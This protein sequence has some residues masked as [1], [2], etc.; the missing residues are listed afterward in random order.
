MT[1]LQALDSSVI[2]TL[3]DQIAARMAAGNQPADSITF[4]E[5]YHHYFERH[6]KVRLKNWQNAHYFFK[7]HGA[8]WSSIK[9]HEI[10]RLDVQAWVDELGKKSPSS[11]TRALNMVKAIINWGMRRELIPQMLNPC[12]GVE[13]FDTPS[14]ERFVLPAELRKLKAALDDECSLMCD[15]FWISL[16]TGARRSN[17]LSMRW[18]EIDFDLATWTIPASKFKNGGS[19]TVPL[20]A[21]VL[22]VL[23]RRLED[24][25]TES[26]WVF[27]GRI[28][29]SHLKEPKRAWQRILDRAEISDLHIHDLRRTMG[30]YMAMNGENQYVIAQMLGHKDLRSTAVYARLNLVT[31]RSASE[32]VS[33]K[34]QKYLDA[35]PVRKVKPLAQKPE[36]Q[37]IQFKNAAAQLSP[38]E[39]L[40]VEGRILTSLLSGGSTKKHFYSR[41][42]SK[43]QVNSRELD[44]VLVEMESRRLIQKRMDDRGVTRYKLA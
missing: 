6:V 32:A 31:V 13:K 23:S 39:Q 24:K 34:L 41:I 22:G 17:V 35:K 12:N 27:P 16:L 2:S 36:S 37:V 1:A 42:G 29:G 21:L 26:P 44:R 11:A 5:L 4:G 28:A 9:V 14:R 10:K 7:V 30:S 25:E 15:F 40:L 43:I 33:L 8:R 3:A 20:C 19:H 18:D 38:V